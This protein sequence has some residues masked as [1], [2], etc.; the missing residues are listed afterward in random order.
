M[1]KKRYREK[2]RERRKKGWGERYKRD[3]KKACRIL[4]NCG[5]PFMLFNKEELKGGPL[6]IRFFFFFFFLYYLSIFFLLCFLSPY[7]FLFMTFSSLFFSS[8]Y[9]SSFCPILISPLSPSLSPKIP[10]KHK[11]KQNQK[12]APTMVP[13]TSNLRKR[14]CKKTTISFKMARQR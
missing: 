13:Q 3:K 2:S 10:K 4:S 6:S 12:T 9:C 5:T 11:T 1:G 8:C 7:F 14:I